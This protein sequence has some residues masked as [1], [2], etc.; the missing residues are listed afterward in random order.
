MNNILIDVSPSRVLF[1]Q[2]LD[3]NAY[4][5]RDADYQEQMDIHFRDFV[6]LLL[7]K[8]H[9]MQEVREMIKHLLFDVV[10]T[11]GVDVNSITDALSTDLLNA[12]ALALPGGLSVHLLAD[13]RLIRGHTLILT[14]LDYLP[15]QYAP[16]HW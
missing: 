4:Y 14:M 11:D 7:G 16:R 8:D 10:G 3:P 2:I 15:P 6:H 13:V 5:A 12:L 1:E 9:T